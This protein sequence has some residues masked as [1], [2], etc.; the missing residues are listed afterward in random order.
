MPN[1]IM[2]TMN[3]KGDI[4]ENE[5]SKF[6]NEKLQRLEEENKE[7][8]EEIE[9]LKK[10]QQGVW[11]IIKDEEDYLASGIL[12]KFYSVIK[13][14]SGAGWEAGEEDVVD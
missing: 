9:K 3:S 1:I 6:W 2:Q 10:Y 14:A 13:D 4:V 5:V 11:D 8:K 7:L 12:N